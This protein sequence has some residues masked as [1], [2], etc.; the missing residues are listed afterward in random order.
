M[1]GRVLIVDDEQHQRDILQMI[2]ESEGYTTSSAA[3]GRQALRLVREQHFDVALT[4]LK[5]PYMSGITLLEE[6]LR[7][8]PGICVLLMTAHGTIDSAVEAMRKGAFDYLTKPLDREEL[9][10]VLK[11]VMERANL[12]RENRML[13]EQLQERFR[14]ENMVGA[15]GSM[16][17]V[18]RLVQKVAPS[19]STVLV[20]GESGTGKELV[21]RAIHHLSPRRN[22]PFYAVSVA[23]LPETLLEA[24]LFGH[25]KGAFTG[26][27]VRK[28]GLFEQA[29]GSTLFLDEVGELK[30]DLQ[31][32]L[33]RV[34][35]EREITRVGGQERIHVDVRIVAATNRD[36]ERAV[37]EGEF[38]DDLYYR[39]NVIPIF[40]PPLR[41]RPTDIP[42]LV[43]HFLA[44]YDGERR[45]SMSAD[46]LRVILAYDWPG[47][48][49]QLESTIERAVLLAEGE[50]ITQEDLPPAVRTGIL[51]PRES[52]ALEIPESGIDL[53]ALERSLILKALEK[54]GGNITRAARLVGLSRR[55]LQYRLEKIRTEPIGAPSAPKGAEADGAQVSPNG[56]HST[57]H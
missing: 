24:E 36:L 21:A 4:D 56:P 35:Q 39:L 31:V 52:L 40:L 51:A 49:R 47:N 32:K 55:T 45:R 7:E 26:A 57:T 9:L 28:V 53:E 3:N 42:L 34:L 25:E 38:R 22:R 50:T 5:M 15:H 1:K 13:Q 54:A 2:L 8:Q 37:R 18:F 6:L 16:Q 10:L 43:E 12:V 30:K 23:A 41:D 29:S 14:L 48:V 44:K 33:L 17:E 46:A 27:E 11:R 19:N 20:Y